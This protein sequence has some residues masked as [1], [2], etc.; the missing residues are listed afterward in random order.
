MK[1]E[2]VEHMIKGNL[3]RMRKAI[4][5]GK[6]DM[7]ST[8]CMETIN[9]CTRRCAY[10]PLSIDK[11]F[12]RTEMDAQLFY[13]IIKELK[14][15]GFKGE[16]NLSNFGE[17]LLDS[18]L[19]YFVSHI[20]SNLPRAKIVFNSNGDLLT[21]RKLNSF[22]NFGVDK[23]TVTSHDKKEF[24]DFP[25]R[26]ARHVKLKT[27]NSYDSRGGS[28]KVSPQ[29]FKSRY[30]R[31]PANMIVIRADGTVPLCCR[32]YFNVIIQG[33]INNESLMEIWNKE[34]NRIRRKKI[35]RGVLRDEICKKCTGT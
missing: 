13:K 32:D 26:L 10:C 6:V 16:I 18:R 17:P 22:V 7:F 2:L 5:L 24:P 35:E 3:S 1:E 34:E 21:R 29:K 27:L 23:I 8:V 9:D 15:I 31:N 25:K 33:N 4:K 19:A 11:T 20:R 14:S 12:K 28:M 30:C